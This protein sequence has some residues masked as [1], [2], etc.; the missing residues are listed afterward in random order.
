VERVLAELGQLNGN[1]DTTDNGHTTDD[2]LDLLVLEVSHNLFRRHCCGYV[3]YVSEGKAICVLSWFETETQTVGGAT[4]GL[5]PL[6][7]GVCASRTLAS[8]SAAGVRMVDPG[9]TVRVVTSASQTT[10][11]FSRAARNHRN[12]SMENPRENIT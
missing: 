10:S 9:T 5:Q 11:T 4:L 8:E 12:A 2:R 1:I 7:G 3:T 6:C